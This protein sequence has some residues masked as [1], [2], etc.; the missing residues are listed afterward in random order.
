MKLAKN[1]GIAAVAASI[2]VV[3]A[4]PAQAALL[5]YN[6]TVNATSGSNPGKYFGSFQY[7]DSDLTNIGFER[8]NVNNGLALTFN[9][10][11]INYTQ[12]N[13]ADFNSFPIVTFNDGQLLGLSYFV[14]D[15][16]VID[17]DVDSLNVGGDRFYVI[18]QSVN[19]IEVGTVSYTRVP[20]PLGISGTAIATVIGLWMQ[21]KK[22]ATKLIAYPSSITLG[23]GKI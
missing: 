2:F 9:Y 20:E 17:S 22:K 13:D 8:L 5:N 19:A 11:G 10:L 3:G 16:F 18:Q 4:K 12:A 7:D 14:P 21:R 15:Q 6:F 1:F 23:R